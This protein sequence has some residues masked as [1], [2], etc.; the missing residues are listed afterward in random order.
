MAVLFLTKAE[1]DDFDGE[2]VPYVA[3]EDVGDLFMEAQPMVVLNPEGD[4]SST[5]PPFDIERLCV[6]TILGGAAGYAGSTIVEG[7]KPK[8]ERHTVPVTLAGM[9]LGVLAALLQTVTERQT[10]ARAAAEKQ[11]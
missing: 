2:D 8:A 1:F 7:K 10:A 5:S 3:E 9:G 6:Y 11:I 4:T